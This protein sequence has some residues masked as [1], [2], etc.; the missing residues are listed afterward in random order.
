ML[1]IEVTS[2]FLKDG[3]LVPVEFVLDEDPILIKDL[4]R[5]WDSSLGKNILVMDFQNQT[6][7]LLFKF[8]DLSWYL[9]MDIKRKPD[10]A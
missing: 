3:S 5:Q 8:E 4:G 1:R 10:S 6:Y 7:H 9:V 2:R